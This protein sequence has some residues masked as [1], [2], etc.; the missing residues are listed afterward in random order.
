[1][2]PDELYRQ[3]SLNRQLLEAAATRFAVLTDGH[4]HP[5]VDTARDRLT[6]SIKA[7][8]QAAGGITGWTATSIDM[9]LLGLAAWAVATVAGEHIGLSSG[10][11]IAATVAVVP[12]LLWPLATLNEALSNT[13]NRRRTTRPPRPSA[14]VA[15]PEAAS[16][17]EILMILWNVRDGLAKVMRGWTA[18][19]RLGAAARTAAGF[20]WL[21]HRD[22]HLFWISEADRGVCQ[23]IDSIELWHQT[24]KRER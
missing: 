13:M 6:L 11:V 21:R 16:T 10:W 5:R 12:A 15:P 9:A 19:H 3:L 14:I 18:G 4:D 22:R 17:S 7:L 8:T 24:R 2:G 20:D 23:A 1:M